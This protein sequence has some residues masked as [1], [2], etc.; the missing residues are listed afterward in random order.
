MEHSHLINFRASTCGAYA[1]CSRKLHQFT[2][3][4]SCDR[5]LLICSWNLK[6][7]KLI[8]L[9]PAWSAPTQRVLVLLAHILLLTIGKNLTRTCH[10]LGIFLC[11]HLQYILSGKT[12]KCL[13]SF[14]FIIIGARWISVHGTIPQEQFVVLWCLQALRCTLAQEGCWFLQ[15][16]H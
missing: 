16:F 1:V 2:V 13:A 5:W 12:E 14:G 6:P 8:I 11:P 3:M 15:T 10:Q 7:V 9:L 4:D